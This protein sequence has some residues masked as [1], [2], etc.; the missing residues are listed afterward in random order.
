MPTSGN[1]YRS[2]ILPAE[3]FTPGALKRIGEGLASFVRT[4]YPAVYLG[5]NTYEGIAVTCVRIVLI[6]V[7]GSFLWRRRHQIAGREYPGEETHPEARRTVE[8]GRWLFVAMCLI[9]ITYTFSFSASWFYTR[10]FSPMA[11]V[12]ISLTAV[13]AHVLTKGKILL[14]RLLTL[15]LLIPILAVVV[16]LHVRRGVAIGGSREL[17]VR[18]GM[19]GHV[20]VGG[21]DGLRHGRH[22]SRPPGGKAMGPSGAHGCTAAVR[23]GALAH[24]LLH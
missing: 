17:P 19:F 10:Y 23:R 5:Q 11:L 7:T 6:A 12:T 21:D 2:W 15:G 24:D 1:A 16:S 3:I 14:P 4:L 8:F 22:V 13:A 9:A 20:R 18:L